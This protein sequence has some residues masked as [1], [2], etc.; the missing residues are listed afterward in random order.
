M[1]FIAPSVPSWTM[2]CFH[3]RTRHPINTL[4]LIENYVQSKSKSWSRESWTVCS[5]HVLVIAVW[6]NFLKPSSVSLTFVL[7]LLLFYFPFFNCHPLFFVFNSLHDI[8]CVRSFTCS[9]ILPILSQARGRNDSSFVYLH[10]LITWSL[11]TA[12]SPTS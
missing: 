7:H 3:F 8:L 4:V 10:S 9:Y 6:F 1:S 2:A 11:P 5:P 12:P